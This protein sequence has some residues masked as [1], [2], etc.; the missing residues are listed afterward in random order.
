MQESYFKLLENNKKWVAAQLTLNPNF[1]SDL[2]KGQKPEY[3]WIGCSDSRVPANEIT[4]T[5]PGDVFV[6]RNIAN[7]VISTDINMLS[8]VAYAIDILKVKHI[9]VC[10]HYGC[11]GIVAA[12]QNKSFGFID[13]WLTNIKNIYEDNKVELD[14]IK[15]QQLKANKLVELNVRR[16]VYELSKISIVQNAWERN[17]NLNI[18][19]WV[20]DI[21][22]G[23][24]Q[25][26]KTTFT[27]NK[28]LDK[29]Y[30]TS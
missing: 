6:H 1:F 16:Q 21:A 4:G 15:D 7:M 17:Q 11:G 28:H 10:G 24:I 3:L 18:H 25:D 8:V 29:V 19:G 30:F 9:I 5:K 20:Y 23:I 2:A 12:L 26:L 22:D 14:A 13:H 27:N